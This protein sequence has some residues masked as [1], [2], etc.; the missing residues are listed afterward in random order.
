VYPRLRSP[1]RAA[2]VVCG[3]HPVASVRVAMVAPSDRRSRSMTR[4]S[5]LPARGAKVLACSSM[6]SGPEALLVSGLDR[7]CGASLGAIASSDPSPTAMAFNPAA[8]SLSA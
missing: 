3:S 5:L 6:V 2:R 8:V 4:A 7:G 1:V